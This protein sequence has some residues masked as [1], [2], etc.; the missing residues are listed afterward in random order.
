[1]ADVTTLEAIASQLPANDTVSD[2]ASEPCNE[3]QRRQRIL[4]L[5]EAIERGEYLVSA[6]Q[7]ADAFLRTR[8]R[9]N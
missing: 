7:L 5:R 4:A 1:M 9:A 6:S 8:R 3:A 2:T